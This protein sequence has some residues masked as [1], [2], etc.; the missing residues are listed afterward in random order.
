MESRLD[1][2][3][4][5]VRAVAQDI[6]LCTAIVRRKEEVLVGFQVSWLARKGTKGTQLLQEAGMR[7]TDEQ[8]PAPDDGLFLLEVPP[9]ETGPW[10]MLIA[11]GADYYDGIEKEDAEDL[12]KGDHEVLFFRCDDSAFASELLL[13]RDGT[14]V[15]SIRHDAEVE[16]E[17][18]VLEG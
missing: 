18:S 12:S 8:Q 13:F 4:A 9:S 16:D 5:R 17:P 6:T 15:W 7:A 3:T 1:R 14:L 10:S 2:V 11:D